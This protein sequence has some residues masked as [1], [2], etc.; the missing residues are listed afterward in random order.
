MEVNRKNNQ[1]AEV[2]PHDKIDITNSDD[3]KNNLLELFD[4]GYKYITIDFSDV[5]GIDSSGL[6]KLLLFQKKLAE[7]NGKLSVVNVKNEYVSKMF[8]MIHLDKVIDIH[9]KE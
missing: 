2:I 7:V 6:G 9:E 5:T 1:S 4:E 3:F 8:K